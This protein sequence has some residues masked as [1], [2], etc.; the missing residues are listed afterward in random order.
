MEEVLTA[1]EVADYLRV[2][3]TTVRRW[4]REGEL[5]A[6]KVGRSYRVRRADLDRWWSERIGRKGSGTGRVQPAESPKQPQA[7]KRHSAYRSSSKQGG[8]ER[9]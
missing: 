9:Q 4:C 1:D 6:V 3:L 5:P 7:H 2:H 8:S